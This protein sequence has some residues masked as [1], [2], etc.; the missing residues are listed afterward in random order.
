MSA[1]PASRAALASS[2]GVGAALS[3]ELTKARRSRV[4]AVSAGA[5]VLFGMV[6]GFFTWVLQD[7][8]RA[9]G[10]GLLGAKAQV[11]G[12]RADWPSYLA[13]TSQS[14]AI[15]G[16]LVFGVVVV[17]IFGREGADGTAKDLLALPTSRSA[18]VAAKG[19]LALG[20]CS[21]LGVLLL[22]SCLVGGMVLT[23]P[24][25]PVDAVVSGSARVLTAAL[26]T[27]VLALVHALAA[28]VGR[29]YLPG[30]VSI[31]ATLSAG[32][33]L[34]ALGFGAWFPFSVPAMLSGAAG[35]DQA[36]VPALAVVLVVATGAAGWMATARWWERA[37]HPR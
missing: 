9:R 3:A 29:G 12:G 34:A 11:L 33:V 20:W 36:V 5:T 28:S 27:A 25:A 2:P 22:G 16:A 37:D 7:P 23:L 1:E 30:M 6:G 4:P 14:A 17:W 31:L 35:Q 24:S 15:G 10:L 8:G 18:V 19:L 32:Q 21:A 13:L 26:L